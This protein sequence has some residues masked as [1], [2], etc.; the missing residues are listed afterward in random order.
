MPR[1]KYTYDKVKKIIEKDNNKL[2]SD[3]YIN[4]KILITI[5]CGECENEY[6]IRFAAYVKGVRCRKCAI[7]K[8]GIQRRTPI[9]DVKK[10]IKERGDI[11][12]GTFYIK[13]RLR[14]KFN[15][16]KCKQVF[17]LVYF[18]YQRRKHCRCE[19]KRKI[20]YTFIKKYV[21][22]Q[23]EILMSEVYLNSYTKIK[24]KCKK[25]SN[26][27]EL[28]WSGYY[29]G[30]RCGDCGKYKKKGY[31]DVKELL[32]S[33][34]DILLSKTYKNCISKLNIE[35]GKCGNR[36]PTTYSGYRQGNRCRKCFHKRNAKRMTHT[37]DYVSSY[38]AK[39]GDKFIDKYVNS[40]FKIKIKCGSCNEIYISSFHAYK[41]MGVRC[42]CH[43]MSRGERFIYY[44]LINNNIKYETQ[45]TFKKCK[46]KI[47]LRFDFYL[48]KY[49][50]LIEFDG[51]AHFK[52]VEFFGGKKYF[53]EK[54]HCDII[55]NVF[56]IKNNQHLLRISYVDIKQIDVILDNYLKNKD[57]SIIECSDYVPY[58]TM[59]IDTY[60][61]MV[62]KAPNQMNLPSSVGCWKQ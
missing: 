8:C 42:L 47:A 3:E 33:G 54:H 55:K 13:N 23:G 59:L 18:G 22:D 2:I 15:C 38:I 31:E 58:M 44:Y 25:Y 14:V 61:N 19:K 21:K 56:C 62:G 39:Y 49:N 26:V 1:S 57:H 30:V 27:Y 28:N 60:K 51:I 9:E 37:Q 20:T 45:K 10:L 34:G 7:V 6:K 32:E 29:R 36:Y 43:T 52:T 41:S 46:N 12:I 16:G 11:F 53:G 35:C 24:I 17:S 50:L 5:L 40:D 4:S 48:P